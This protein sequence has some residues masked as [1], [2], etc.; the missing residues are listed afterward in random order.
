MHQVTVQFN[1]LA[2]G[3]VSMRLFDVTGRELFNQLIHVE[4]GTKD[5]QIPIDGFSKGIYMFEITHSS[6]KKS[7]KFALTEQ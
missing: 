2:A 3:P 6:F 4:G 5:V 7:L 1:Q